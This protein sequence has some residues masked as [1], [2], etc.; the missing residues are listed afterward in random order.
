MAFP[1]ILRSGVLHPFGVEDKARVDG[2]VRTVH[3]RKLVG[4]WR[5]PQGLVSAVIV[6][7]IGKQPVY[8]RAAHPEADARETLQLYAACH[9]VAQPFEKMKCDGGL[10]K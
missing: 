9:A 7:G 6:C 8:L 3:L 5:G 4:L 2:L 1:L 10:G